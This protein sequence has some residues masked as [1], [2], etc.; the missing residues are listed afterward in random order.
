MY[1]REEVITRREVDAVLIPSAVPITIPK[2]SHV[3]IVQALG[4]TFTVETRG[5]LARVLGKDA[6]ALGKK[7]I[8]SP[9][10]RVSSEVLT[11]ELVWDVLRTCY[12]P[13]IPINI[14]ELGLI[15]ECKLLSEPQ[16]AYTI[17]IKMTLTAPGCGMGPVLQSEVEQKLKDLPDVKAVH[18]ELVFDP[19]WDRSRMS[20][21]AQLQL[22]ML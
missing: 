7:A 6:D 18:V 3:A 16:G 17:S 11:E 22:G 14:V 20:E 13:E 9:R 10:Q 5:N 21:A 8:F 15:Y 2:G 1:S 4:D 12:D 19:P